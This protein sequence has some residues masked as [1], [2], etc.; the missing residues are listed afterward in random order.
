MMGSEQ[1]RNNPKVYLAGVAVNLR[2][3]SGSAPFRTLYNLGDPGAVS[4]AGRKGATKTRAWKLSLRLFSR[5][6]W[7]APGS[8]RMGAVR[9]VHYPFLCIRPTGDDS[10]PDPI[11]WPV[12]VAILVLNLTSNWCTTRTFVVPTAQ[13]CLFITSFLYRRANAL[14]LFQ[15]GTKAFVAGFHKTNDCV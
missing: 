9:I 12:F 8:P 11:V 14:A 3:I 15:Y 4:R 7:F 5:P 6:D 2:M 10:S 1:P 13:F